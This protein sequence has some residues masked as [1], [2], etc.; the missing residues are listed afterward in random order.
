MLSQ[1]AVS[2]LLLG[3]MVFLVFYTL[4]LSRQ[5]READRKIDLLLA[6]FNGLRE[7][8]Y[9]IDPQFNDE[10][11]SNNDMDDESNTMVAFDDM[12]LL[13]AKEAAGHRTLNSPFA[14]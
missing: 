12:K 13:E 7:Y 11:E 8:L 14:R 10:R 6:N 4:S 3:G 2:S 9:E 5:L 1:S